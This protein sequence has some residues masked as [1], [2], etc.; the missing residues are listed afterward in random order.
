MNITLSEAK[1]R[2]AGAAAATAHDYRTANKRFTWTVAAL[3][4]ASGLVAGVIARGAVVTYGN[5]TTIQGELPP[6]G[7]TTA[8]SNYTNSSCDGLMQKATNNT[9]SG[10]LNNYQNGQNQINQQANSLSS[11]LS[12][13]ANMAL[14][15][16]P[17]LN[18]GG[19]VNA[20]ENQAC[21]MAQT[22]MTQVT[23][24]LYSSSALNPAA[25]AGNVGI[26]GTGVSLANGITQGPPISSTSIFRPQ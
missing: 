18:I 8:F 23:G 12:N 11:C 1:R 2:L 4:L 5:T 7:Y 25:L 26:R 24:P 19:L 20:L 14:P 21:V 17:S 6:P 3:F 9:L 10:N 15:G 13:M 16:I 22:A